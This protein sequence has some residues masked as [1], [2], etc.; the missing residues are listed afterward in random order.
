MRWRV[1]R[2]HN[3]R[4]LI[5]PHWKLGIHS[6]R[7]V[8]WAEIARAVRPDDDQSHW[9]ILFVETKR[10]AAFAIDAE[11]WR[12]VHHQQVSMH[13]HKINRFAMFVRSRIVELT[14]TAQNQ[15]QFGLNHRVS[16]IR[17]AKQ[18]KK[19]KQTMRRIPSLHFTFCVR[20]LTSDDA[21]FNNSQLSLH[22]LLFR[23]TINHANDSHSFRVV[24]AG[25]V[26]RHRFIEHL[27][28]TQRGGIQSE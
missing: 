3:D 17:W 7:A 16:P 23:S 12:P 18:K 28:S 4:H 5:S 21:A 8:H 15:C 14:R 22:F 27:A 19:N 9:A 10:I 13:E 26:V 2:R 25:H 6:L 11:I 20:W 24:C 1:E